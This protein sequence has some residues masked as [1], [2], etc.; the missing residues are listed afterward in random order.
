M[1]P[2]VMVKAMLEFNSKAL[3]LER[4]VGSFYQ[5][6]LKEDSRTKVEEL[7]SQI[8]KNVEENAA[9]KKE[10][11]EWLE[12][13]KRLGTWKVRCLE[14]EKKLKARIVDLKADYDELKEKHDNLKMELEDL[15]GC[16]TQENI[17]SFQKG[18]RQATSF[19]KDIDAFDARFDVNKDV[20]DG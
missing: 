17:N 7:Q 12:E 6:E 8:D 2:N 3:I 5:R 11:E 19:Y 13:K 10:K 15:K 4:Q 20:V 16:I 14:S 9:W 1:E 18:L